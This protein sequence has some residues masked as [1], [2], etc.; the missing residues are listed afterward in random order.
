MIKRVHFPLVEEEEELSDDEQYEEKEESQD[1]ISYEEE[2]EMS[3]SEES[4]GSRLNS[5]KSE[6]WQTA[7]A[8]QHGLKTSR[9]ASKVKI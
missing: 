1:K 6:E 9:A 5:A 3:V 7:T 2:E 4:D 8:E